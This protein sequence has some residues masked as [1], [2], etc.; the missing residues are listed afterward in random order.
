[1]KTLPCTDSLLLLNVHHI[2][3]YRIKVVDLKEI[4]ILCQHHGHFVK[5]LIVTVPPPPT[6]TL[7]GICLHR[8]VGWL[9]VTNRSS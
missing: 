7:L 9:F 1:M 6:E 5:F 8:Y 2:E 3:N 4:Y